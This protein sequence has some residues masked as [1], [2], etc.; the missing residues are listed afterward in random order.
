MFAL[1]WI[2]GT[3]NTT[4]FAGIRCFEH[5]FGTFLKTIYYAGMRIDVYENVD[6]HYLKDTIGQGE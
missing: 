5:Q 3:K 1:Y 2:N 6:V 4:D